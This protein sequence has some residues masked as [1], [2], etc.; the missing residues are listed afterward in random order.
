[1]N[2]MRSRCHALTTPLAA[3]LL[4]PLLLC[5]LPSAAQENQ[6]GRLFHS[7]EQRAQLDL[8]RGVVTPVQSGGPQ[9]TIVNGIITRSGQAPILFIDGKDTRGPATR[10]SAQQQL[11]QGVPLKSESGQT[12]AAQPG[13]IVD[14]SSGKTLETYQLVPGV[15]DAAPRES[16]NA[17]L[18]SGAPPPAAQAS[19]PG[20]PQ[21]PPAPR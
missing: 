21:P 5:P 15:A 3:T 14:L 17:P 20:R 11:N 4:C 6:L 1:M 2:T 8:K 13:Q 19:A 16:G 12:F 7:P 9:T 18:P 10:A